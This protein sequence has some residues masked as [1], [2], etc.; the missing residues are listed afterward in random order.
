MFGSPD[1]CGV[2]FDLQGNQLIVT[3]PDGLADRLSGVFLNCSP[4]GQPVSAT[5]RNGKIATDSFSLCNS[6]GPVGTLT[7]GGGGRLS[8][9]DVMIGNVGEGILDV[10]AGGTLQIGVQTIVGA[11]DGAVGSLRVT[12]TGAEVVPRDEEESSTLIV[13]CNGEGTM[14]LSAGSFAKV[15][16]ANIGRSSAE[17][18]ESPSNSSR[19]TLELSGTNTRAEFGELYLGGGRRRVIDPS[20][21]DGI[22]TAT[23]ANGAIIETGLLHVFPRGTLE[24]DGGS[25]VVTATYLDKV[26]PPDTV[27][28]PDST[29]KIVVRPGMRN[30]ALQAQDLTIS[31]AKLEITAE[32]GYRPAIGTKIPLISFQFRD[33]DNQ[34][35]GVPDGAI[36]EFGDAALKI[37]YQDDL[38]T[39]TVVAK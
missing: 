7:I 39:G 4:N 32:S 37:T 31:G 9:K 28:A 11:A 3:T 13:G 19:G 15:R 20:F 24:I 23:V 27:F 26:L 5:I 2:Q 1:G 33:A 29:L 14:T 21:A 10:Q 8:A 30:P 35:D 6:P 16:L 22:G 18:V 25:V 36:V 12:G 34:F 38:I 17:P